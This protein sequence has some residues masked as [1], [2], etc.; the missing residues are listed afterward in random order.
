[1]LPQLKGD[2][3]RQRLS[4]W[5]RALVTLE[6]PAKQDGV[7]GEVCH[8]VV[9][10]CKIAQAP[11]SRIILA[12]QPLVVAPQHAVDGAFTQIEQLLLKLG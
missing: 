7:V 3:E 11:Q 12:E 8:A 6:T 9:A 2:V 5:G 10:F 1:M 4:G